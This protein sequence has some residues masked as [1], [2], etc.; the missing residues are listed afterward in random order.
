MTMENVPILLK[1][2][3]FR[4]LFPF[5]ILIDRDSR[6]ISI[7]SSLQK[8][9]RIGLGS[10]F[11]E[12]FS[13]NRPFI[14]QEDFDTLLEN[15]QV[16]FILHSVS[17]PVMKL[18]G[19][20]MRPEG[21]EELLF[22]GS[23]WFDSMQALKEQR[24]A[25][26][27]FALHD[28]IIDL[29]H[30]LKTNEIG[31]EDVKE[32][33]EKYRRQQQELK[34]LSIIATE[35]TNMV[36]VSNPKGE[37]EWVN[38]AFEEK[39][40]FTLQEVQGKRPGELRGGPA[41]DPETERDIHESI[42]AGKPFV[43]ELQAYTKDGSRTWIRI[44]GQPVFDNK[45]ILE[46]YFAIEED[47]TEQHEAIIRL[48][49]SEE[50]YRNILQNM[51]LGLVELDSE[52]R[53]SYFNDNFIRLTG[54]TQE[55]TAGKTLDELL[56]L[57]NWNYEPSFMAKRR[58]H[59]VSE[60]FEAEL[61][62]AAG[63]EKW[64]LISK[65][66]QYDTKQMKTG[67]VVILL[68]IT[69]RKRMEMELERAR[70]TAEE[71]SRAKESFLINMSHEIRT[72]MNIIMGMSRHLSTFIR[73]EKQMRF[74]RSI[75]SAADNLL[76]VINDVLDIAKIEA[77]KLE[78]E[79]I[80]FRLRKSMEEVRN[81]LRFSAQEKGLNFSIDIDSEVPDILVGDPYRLNQILMNLGGN[82]MKFTETGSVEISVYSDE[83]NG[84][85][86]LHFVIEDTGIGI[87]QEK[88]D[89]VFENFRQADGSVSRKYGG[90]G[91][92]LTISR[93]LAKLMGGDLTLDSHSGMG[94][95]VMLTL[96]FR[97]GIEGEVRLSDPDTVYEGQLDGLRILVV[98]DNT[99]NLMLAQAVLESLGATV[100]LA[101]SGSAAL[102]KLESE[103]AF[104]VIL[105][106]IQMPGM[107]GIETTTKLRRELGVKT[108]VIAL[109]ANT[110]SEIRESLKGA[111][112]DDHLL[113]PYK[114]TILVSKIRQ[115]LGKT[116]LPEDGS[117]KKDANHGGR[118][119]DTTK[120]EEFSVNNPDF[121]RKMLQLFV[122]E[123]T[124]G[125]ED[126]SKALA[127]KKYR[128][129]ADLAHRMKPSF[130]QLMIDPLFHGIKRL[131]A[132]AKE[133]DQS[134]ESEKLLEELRA[135]HGK[136]VEQIRSNEL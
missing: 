47:I 81:L 132:L 26:S 130:D 105:M 55:D 50:K 31:M 126:L 29:L 23:P 35:S 83:K 24:L 32:M 54:F 61:T 99:M 17:K 118:L 33:L 136:V 122:E 34:K 6:I 79:E 107:D 58:T 7:G 30:I 38:R 25:I 36:V 117:R 22:V 100:V 44:N 77:G 46:H 75:I 78:I 9:L 59:N 84:L 48:Q 87:P 96:P 91:L 128:E 56:T 5:H 134:G 85:P 21:Q 57:R 67:S 40:G 51:D 80:G 106:D 114:E 14:L 112:I 95:R 111:G 97:K 129:A 45:G 65:A 20:W 49:L 2:G 53:I 52:G 120:L 15:S 121:L 73:D 74:L 98:E 103:P 93:Q 127:G 43:H 41:T 110:S 63:E 101:D 13:V 92:G 113:K 3:D 102:K 116:P 8:S 109:T 62:D 16:L 42:R 86:L 1:D 18:R 104:D 119:Y 88:L 108:P 89:E 70:K 123:T 124:A 27:D 94:T 125:F 72:P 12:C 71:S 131:E 19:N 10:P 11:Q 76:V 37:I 135:I 133:E 60:L 82:A 4:R 39:T 69:W 66:L 28:P 64:V 68:D 90:S 115:Q